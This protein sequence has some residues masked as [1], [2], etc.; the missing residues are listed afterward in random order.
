MYG[1]MGEAETDALLRRYRYGRV[2]FTLNAGVYVIPI[3]YA[4]DGIRLYGQAQW[5]LRDKLPEGRRS[6]ACATTRTWRSGS[7][8]SR[9]RRTG[10][11]CCCRAGFTS[12]T[13]TRERKQPSHRYWPRQAME[14]EVK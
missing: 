14:S 12:C 4:Y 1:D 11:A 8:R 13:I 6:R 7:M 3:N 10:A 2:A 9:T 5:W